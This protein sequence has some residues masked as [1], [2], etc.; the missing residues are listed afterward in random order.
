M[1]KTSNFMQSQKDTDLEEE[2]KELSRWIRTERAVIFYFGYIIGR[3]PVLRKQIDVHFRKSN[4][5]P[6][7]MLVVKR[8]KAFL[9]IEFEVYSSNTKRHF[10]KGKTLPY[11]LIV[12]WEH[13]WTELVS[14]HHVPVFELSSERVYEP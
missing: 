1:E 7:A 8:P 12:C 4:V 2:A 6:D 10:E 5:S 11:T 14:K 13:D 3:D 9:N